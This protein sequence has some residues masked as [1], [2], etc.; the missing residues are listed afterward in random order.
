MKTVLRWDFDVPVADIFQDLLTRR[1]TSWRLVTFRDV[2]GNYHAHH[3]PV[4]IRDVMLYRHLI[5]WVH[6]H[7]GDS[8]LE[9]TPKSIRIVTRDSFVEAQLKSR[10]TKYIPEGYKE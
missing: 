8:R 3:T 9:V 6:F 4:D 1:D 5:E 7:H 2:R 10:I